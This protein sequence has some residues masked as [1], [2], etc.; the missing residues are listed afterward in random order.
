MS[1]R[2]MRDMIRVCG[3]ED[4]EVVVHPDGDHEQERH[5]RRV[6]QKDWAPGPEGMIFLK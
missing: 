4:G 2:G 6:E 3:Q 1:V 5:A